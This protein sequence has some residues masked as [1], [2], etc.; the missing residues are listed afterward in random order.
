M[1]I[2]AK[3]VLIFLAAAF[4]AACEEKGPMEELGADLDEMADEVE[5]AVDD[6]CEELKEQVDAQ[7]TDC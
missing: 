7:D 5:Q 4:T 6:A 1:N 2:L 3:W